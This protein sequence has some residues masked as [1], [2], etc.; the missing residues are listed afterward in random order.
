MHIRMTK[1][2]VSTAPPKTAKKTKVTIELSATGLA[3]LRKY[4]DLRVSVTPET[5]V[6]EYIKFGLTKRWIKE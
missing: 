1:K 2:D 3:T 4:Y 5:V 6:Q